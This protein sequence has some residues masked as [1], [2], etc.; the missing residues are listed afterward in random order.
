MIHLVAMK[1]SDLYFY[2]FIMSHIFIIIIYVVDIVILQ[3]RIWQ[4]RINR[5]YIFECFDSKR[6]F[7]YFLSLY[8]IA[9]FRIPALCDNLAIARGA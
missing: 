2:R 6:L 9:D 1:V 4:F 5:Y 7:E 3:S 8:S